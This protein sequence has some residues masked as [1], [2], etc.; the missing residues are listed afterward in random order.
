MDKGAGR[1]SAHITDESIK[2]VCERMLCDRRVRVSD[3]KNH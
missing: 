3:V 2:G 1:P